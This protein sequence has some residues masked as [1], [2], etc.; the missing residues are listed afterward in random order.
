MSRTPRMSISAGTPV[1]DLVRRRH[2]ETHHHPTNGTHTMTATNSSWTRRALALSAVL[3]AA[4]LLTSCSAD[5]PNRDDTTST[6]TNGSTFFS[7]MRDKGYDAPD[8]EAGEKS[9]A[10]EVPAGVDPEQWEADTGECANKSGSGA[11]GAEKAV[12]D[13]EAEALMAKA[14]ECVRENGF[15]DYPDDPDKM[16]SYK[17]SDPDTFQDVLQTCSEKYFGKRDSGGAR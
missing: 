2:D 5:K 15:S 8:P 12:V 7:C 14:A 17:A 3:L 9:S 10:F 16:G 4:G 1:S 13:P 11:G 6:T